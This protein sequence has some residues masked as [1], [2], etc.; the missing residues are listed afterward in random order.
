MG[1]SRVRNG[2]E[3]PDARSFI[4]KRNAQHQ[5]KLKQ[6]PM[7]FPKAGHLVASSFASLRR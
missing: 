1:L 4:F 5:L 6:L 3:Q 2:V 7:R